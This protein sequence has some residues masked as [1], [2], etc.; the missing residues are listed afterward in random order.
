M[1]MGLKD[2]DVVR[3]RVPGEREVIFGDTLIRV[4][5][6]F[7]LAMHL[8]TDEGNAADI[9]TGMVGYIE[10][11]QSPPLSRGVRPAGAMAPD[12]RV[13]VKQPVMDAHNPPRNGH[14]R[15]TPKSRCR[16]KTFPG[17]LPCQS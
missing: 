11:I 17:Q 9:T 7:R 14:C 6:N 12:L 16:E 4:K 3:V 13:V 1:S 15:L 8:D 10:G 5:S 2:K